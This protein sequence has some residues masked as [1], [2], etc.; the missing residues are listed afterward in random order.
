MA[1]T[2]QTK[3]RLTADDLARIADLAI[4]WASRIDRKPLAMAEVVRE[5]VER[6]WLQERERRKE[7]DHD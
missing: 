6:C 2:P 1:R 7:T 5:A 4:D 3:L